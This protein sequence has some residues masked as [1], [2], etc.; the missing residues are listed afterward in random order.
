MNQVFAKVL[1]YLKNWG[2]EIYYCWNYGPSK[3]LLH[4]F[5]YGLDQMNNKHTKTIFWRP[6]S[7]EMSAKKFEVFLSI[8]HKMAGQ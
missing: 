8:H 6:L 4:F 2:I 7:Q 1:S 5:E 3:L